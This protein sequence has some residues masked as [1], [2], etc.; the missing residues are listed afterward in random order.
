MTCDAVMVVLL[1]VP[2]TR[3]CLPA[4]TALADAGLDPS[5][6]VVADA[7]STVTFW[8]AGV[9]SVKPDADTLVTVPTDPPAADP[10]RALDPVPDLCPATAPPG[11]EPPA[12]AEDEVED[13]DDEAQPAQ[14]PS[15]ADTRTAAAI[16][17][18][19]CSSMNFPF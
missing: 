14:T 8:P 18:L 7:S 1:V 9:V 10:D 12:A 2:S 13:E 3:T 17:P 15:T 6:Y 19:L 16:R 4:V 5:W 11:A